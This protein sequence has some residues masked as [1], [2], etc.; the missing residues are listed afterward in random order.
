MRGNSLSN[1]LGLAL[2]W[3][4]LACLLPMRGQLNCRS[5][6]SIISGPTVLRLYS[7]CLDCYEIGWIVWAEKTISLRVTVVSGPIP[8]TMNAFAPCLGALYPTFCFCQLFGTTS[9]GERWFRST[10]LAWFYGF[11]IAQVVW[12][13]YCSSTLIA[14][15]FLAEVGCHLNACLTSFVS[16]IRPTLNQGSSYFPAAVTLLV[17]YSPAQSV[18][19]LHWDFRDGVWI[20]YGLLDCVVFVQNDKI[21]WMLESFKQLDLHI[22]SDVT[23]VDRLP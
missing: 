18:L 1:G 20:V 21:V 15:D 2:E 5:S 23:I 13:S 11:I 22:C 17:L 12:F 14:F 16:T 8:T 6:C 9:I 10:L 4:G 3:L 7:D 19:R